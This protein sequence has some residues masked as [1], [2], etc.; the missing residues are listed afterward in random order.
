MT[1]DRSWMDQ[2]LCRETMPDA[3][4]P[5]EKED[6]ALNTKAQKLCWSCPVRQQCLDY[7]IENCEMYGIWGGMSAHQR[8][9]QRRAALHGVTVECDAD[10]TYRIDGV[11]VHGARAVD[12]YL[13]GYFR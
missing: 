5:E 11:V 9:L 3:F 10:H 4:F 13:T 12:R 2:A 6:Q 8:N 1:A 7:A